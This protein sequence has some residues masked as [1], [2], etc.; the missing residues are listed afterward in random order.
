MSQITLNLPER[1][2]PDP[3]LLTAPPAE[4]AAVL[5]IATRTRHAASEANADHTAASV[6]RAAVSLATEQLSTR[7]DAERARADDTVRK[8]H[9]AECAL[10]QRAAADDTELHTRINQ[11]LKHNAELEQKV[12]TAHADAALAAGNAANQRILDEVTQRAHVEAAFSDLRA[13][14]AEETARLT[15]RIADLEAPFARGSTAE[16]DAAQTLRQSGFAV[17]DTSDGAQRNAGYLDLLVTAPDGYRLAIEVKNKAVIKMAS[18]DKLRRRE[19]DVDDE[20]QQLKTFRH[21]ARDGVR[22]G[23]FDAATFV[24]VRAH[25]KVANGAPV[26]LEL[27]DD[28][29]G[30]PFAPLSYLG[31]EKARVIT[32]LTNEQLETHVHTVFCTLERCRDLR[33]ECREPHRSPTTRPPRSRSSSTTSAPTS[34]GPSQTCANRRHSHATCSQTSQRCAPTPR[35]HSATCTPSTT[36]VP[37]S[38]AP[39]SDAYE[40]SKARAATMK[41][42]D[43]WRNANKQ[44]AIIDATIGKDAMLMAIRAELA[45]DAA[46]AAANANSA[47]NEARDSDDQEPPNSPQH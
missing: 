2:T 21:R 38:S 10:A 46:N 45:E 33:R 30:R 18:D 20:P 37:G 5:D 8:L 15:K 43:V 23:L 29:T 24:S 14:T 6:V 22:N 39:S 4:V 44:K 42:H 19:K 3:W 36:R 1:Y 35:A 31:P 34:T 28:A 41:D 26:S 25:T 32:P 7:I 17:D 11:L 13:T 27:V 12:T 40:A 16:F 47:N 9:V